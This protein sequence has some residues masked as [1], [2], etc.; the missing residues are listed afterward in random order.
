M[1]TV[2]FSVLLD[3][4]LSGEKHH[5]IRKFNFDRLEQASRLGIQVY[6]KQRVMK[7]ANE[8]HHLFDTTLEKVQVLKFTET[9][10]PCHMAWIYPRDFTRKDELRDAV[11][12]LRGERGEEMALYEAKALARK[13]GFD[14]I[15]TMSKKFEEMYKDEHGGLWAGITF[16]PPLSMGP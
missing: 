4:V 11:E 14:H 2:S 10:W 1:V 9:W 3:K 13:D 15:V 8:P 5:T 16:A 7:P 6:W 12:W